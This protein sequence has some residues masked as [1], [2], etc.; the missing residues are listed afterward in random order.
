MNREWKIGASQNRIGQVS[1]TYVDVSVTHT[2][3]TSAYASAD[4]VADVQEIPGVA[5]AA[6]GYAELVAIIIH[7]EDDQGVALNFVFSQVNTTFGTENS[8]PNIADADLRTVQGHI[9][10]ATTDYLDVGGAKIGSK[11]G[12]TGFPMKCA[13]DSTSLWVA[14]V[15]GSGTPTFSATGLRVTYKFRRHS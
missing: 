7:D 12:L 10:V 3:D 15:N 11:V 4:L 9:G 13:S 8:A 2:L 1:N 6:G 5:L 14:I